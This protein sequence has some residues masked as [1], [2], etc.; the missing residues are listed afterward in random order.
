[1]IDR[2]IVYPFLFALILAA[3]TFWTTPHRPEI[4]PLPADWTAAQQAAFYQL[5]VFPDGAIYDGDWLGVQARTELAPGN[6]RLQV[7]LDSPGGSALVEGSVSRSPLGVF[8]LAQWP[9]IWNSTGSPGWHTLY[10]APAG[11]AGNDSFTGVPTQQFPLRILPAAWRPALRKN[12]G[13]KE[14]ESNCCSYY[15]LSGTESE[16]DLPELIQLAEQSYLV[17]TTKMTGSSPKLAVVFLPRLY[18][19]GGLSDGEGVLSYQDRN[20]TGTE[21]SVVLTH[22]MVHS[23]ADT[24]FP[25]GRYPPTMLNEGWAVYITG[26]HYRTPEPLEDRAAVVSSSGLYVPLARLADSFYQAQHETAYIEAGAFVEFLVD[27]FGWDRVYAMFRDPKNNQPPSAALDSML[28][29]NFQ[30]SLADCES[31]WLAALRSRAPDSHQV[32][33]V[34]FSIAFFDALRRYQELYTPGNNVSAMWVP[35][36]PSARK[37]GMTADYFPSPESAEAIALETMFNAAQRLAG[38]R[39]WSGAWAIQDAIEK[40]LDARQR[41]APDPAFASPLAND[42]RRLVSAVLRGGSEPLEILLENGRAEVT[43]RPL[44]GL[45]K[46]AQT[47]RQTGGTWSRVA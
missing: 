41:R 40:V 39:D 21:F 19:Q 4:R 20:T 7:R 46:G 38:A 15:Y 29:A 44:N 26:G 33:D 23:V 24:V 10:V 1:M 30:T 13:W 2:R 6:T 37:R 45:E 35:D 11:A 47:W 18:G 17:I 27:R 14:A 34:K 16:R 42:Y 36:L 28:R 3:A 9:W 31:E 43:V 32:R 12:A 8:W 22:E 25:P 5:T